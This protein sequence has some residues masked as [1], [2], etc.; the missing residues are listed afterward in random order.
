M[1]KWEYMVL[2]VEYDD[3][4]E[5][6]VKFASANNHH[7]LSNVPKNKLA[8]FLEE[9]DKSGWHLENIHSKTKTHETY[10]FKHPL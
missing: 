6:I 10:N 8:T 7:V 1:Q 3:K 2:N 5:T 9:L 4:N